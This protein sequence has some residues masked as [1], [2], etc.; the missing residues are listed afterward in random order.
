[1]G[2]RDTNPCPG[3]AKNPRKE[4]ARF[5]DAEELARLGR[6]L[7][8]REAEW[9]EA[10]A[11]IR[12]L[13]LSRCR[14]IEVLILR[15]RDIGANAINLRESQTGR[16]GA[17][18]G[19]AARAH[20]AALPATRNLDGF[21]FPRYAGGRGI[22]IL[23]NCRR[24]VCADAKLRRPRLHDVQHTAASRAVMAG[25]N[26]RLVGR[27]LGHCR[28][29]TTADYPHVADG[30]LVEAVDNFGTIIAGAMGYGAGSPHGESVKHWSCR[31]GLLG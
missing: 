2:E 4:L 15:W 17:P 9:P 26:L 10:V 28:H 6:A 22:W 11:A 25:E 24:T 27:L 31:K 12:L 13:A 18:L 5:L 14:R 21:V 16:R 29:R 7:D 19:V 3:F 8:A 23:T 20:I 30:H 1:M